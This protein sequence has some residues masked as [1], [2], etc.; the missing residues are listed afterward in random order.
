MQ[1][2]R[3]PGQIASDSIIW[4]FGKVKQGEIVQHDFVFK[5]ES[6]KTLNIKEVNTSC[7]CTVSKVMKKTLLPGED[8]VIEVK[9]NS[10]GYWSFVQQ[11][12]YVHTDNLDKPL[13]RYIIKGD[14]V[15]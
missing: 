12:V 8:T 6:P 1:K 4:D 5:N 15:L 13:I 2:Y 9:F 11:F 10:K 3:V 14:V 7:G